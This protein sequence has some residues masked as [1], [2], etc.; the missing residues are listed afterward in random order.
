MLWLI[1][2]ENIAWLWRPPTPNSDLTILPYGW[3]FKHSNQMA[4]SILIRAPAVLINWIM[5]EE[6]EEEDILWKLTIDVNF[7]I[8][9]LRRQGPVPTIPMTTRC[10]NFHRSLIWLR[11]SHPT[12]RIRNSYVHCT[13]YYTKIWIAS[14]LAV[15]IILSS[16][17][18]KY[19]F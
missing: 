14:P 1:N 2:S 6:E 10:I 12:I 13:S 18:G 3:K 19:W 16:L 17:S 5:F 8:L 7:D 9:H 15:F 11:E 4:P